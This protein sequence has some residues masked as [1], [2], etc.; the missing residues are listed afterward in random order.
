VVEEWSVV[1]NLSG[2]RVELAIASGWREDDFVLAPSKYEKRKSEMGP[3]VELLRRLWRGESYEGT[4][5][6]GKTI[7]VPVFPRPVQRELPLW[8]TSAGSLRTMVNAGG[9]GFGLLTHMLGQDY[10]EVEKKVAQY[11]AYRARAGLA[12]PGKV[13]LMLHTFVAADRDQAREIV[14][15]S[16]SAY[17]LNSADL[18]IPVGYRDQWA[19]A[20]K[21]SLDQMVDVAFERYFET[22]SLMGSVASCDATVR[23]L[24]DIGVT[25]ICCLVDFG[26]E[27][28]L[29]LKNMDYL[30][31]LKARSA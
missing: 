26:L 15:D 14:R 16:M 23:R 9:A 2:G 28:S 22:A 13:A 24:R 3:Q 29:I 20:E 11:N 27:P 21:G 30:T 6:G 8:I 10:A 1:D 18:S 5:G 17:L 7:Q 25:E 12:G 19:T 4:N 31:E